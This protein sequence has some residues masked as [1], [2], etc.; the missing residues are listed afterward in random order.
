MEQCSGVLVGFPFVDPLRIPLCDWTVEP[1]SV[2]S[3][4][5]GGLAW[6]DTLSRLEAS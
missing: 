3:G 5:I 4:L 6:S 1:R 2:W